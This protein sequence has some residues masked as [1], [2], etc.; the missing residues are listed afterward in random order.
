MDTGIYVVLPF[1]GRELIR[2]FGGEGGT[3]S[4]RIFSKP[5]AINK[6]GM[7]L[8]TIVWVGLAMLFSSAWWVIE[9]LC[10]T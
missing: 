6:F 7:S 8:P 9:D 2:D 10:W 3:K 4:L 1:R 5:S